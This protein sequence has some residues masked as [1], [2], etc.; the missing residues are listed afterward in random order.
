MKHRRN[1]F[2]AIFVLALG[3]V[4]LAY[5]G[6]SY[7]YAAEFRFA[8][9]LAFPKM[10]DKQVV[11]VAVTLPDDVFALARQDFA[12]VRIVDA[13]G[14][15]VPRIIR[16]AVSQKDV[17]VRQYQTLYPG[18]AVKLTPHPEGELEVVVTVPENHPPIEGLRI[19]TPL[20]NFEQSA[21]VFTGEDGA[22]WQPL[23]KE[24]VLCD[25]SQWM[26]VRNLEIAFPRPAS[27]HLRIVFS[28]P[29]IEK[30]RE[31]RDV[32]RRLRDG[33]EVE[34][35]EGTRVERVPFRVDRIES[36]HDVVQTGKLEPQQRETSPA[37]LR[38]ET[39]RS[40]KA[41]VVTVKMGR[42]PLVGVIVETKDRNF[43]RSVKVEVPDESAAGR[44]RHVVAEGSLVRVELPGYRREDLTITFPEQ[45]AEEYRLIIHDGDNKPLEI[46]GIRGVAHV[47]QA[48]FLIEGASKPDRTYRLCYGDELADPPDYDVAAVQAALSQRLAPAE[49]EVGPAEELAVARNPLRWLTKSADTAAVLIVL[50]LI[51][52]AG[53]GWSLYRAAGKFPASHEE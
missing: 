23:V 50:V 49:A 45:R 33:N 36:W 11:L 31:W 52:A 42:R 41:T 27:R 4:G 21:R 1:L 26:N 13:Q 40:R 37:E 7:C 15:E 25:Y 29:S 8:R 5:G 53:M 10:E 39:D 38:L 18:A 3:L 46:T 22:E 34:R 43:R 32:V 51:L 35:T 2:T 24:A 20:T 48:L 6:A 9:S 19:A 17:M 12:D 44:G 47:Y 16:R 14:R 28:E 30:A